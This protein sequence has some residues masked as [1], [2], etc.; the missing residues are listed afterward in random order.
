MKSI[1]EAISLDH[2]L[3]DAWIGH[4]Q[5]TVIDNS[6]GFKKKIENTIDA[7][8]KFIG[9]PNPTSFYK[10]FLLTRDPEIPKEI[11]KEVFEI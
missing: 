11:K 4:P 6:A 1:E 5:F 8:L 2:R 10:K 9:L 7:V 3:V